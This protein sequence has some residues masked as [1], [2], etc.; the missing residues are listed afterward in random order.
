MKI[1]LTVHKGEKIT[2]GTIADYG[3]KLT[4]AG[5]ENLVSECCRAADL[6]TPV[7]LISHFSHFHR[8]NIAKFLPRDFLEPVDFDFITVENCPD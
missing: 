5:F 2:Y 3:K 7:F 6:A 8:F 1:W 4:R